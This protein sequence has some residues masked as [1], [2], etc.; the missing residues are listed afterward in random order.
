MNTNHLNY[1]LNYE[2]EKSGFTLVGITAI[3]DALRPGVPTSVALC[4]SAFCKS[5]C[6]Y[7]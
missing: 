7:W 2:I 5:Y 6:D 1:D 3:N 4:H